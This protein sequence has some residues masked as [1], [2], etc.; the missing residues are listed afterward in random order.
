MSIPLRPKADFC[1]QASKKSQLDRIEKEVGEGDVV[2][3]LH[4]MRL[5]NEAPDYS[6]NYIL[7]K[8]TYVP[9]ESRDLHNHMPIN[10]EK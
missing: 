3:L 4:T 9:F 6:G 5:E 10:N 8:L 1:L 7:L 2:P